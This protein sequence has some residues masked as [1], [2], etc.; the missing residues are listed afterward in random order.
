MSIQ[1]LTAPKICNLP[2]SVFVIRANGSIDARFFTT[3]SLAKCWATACL[4]LLE[5]D[6]FS[7]LNVHGSSVLLGKRKIQIL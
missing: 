1:A 5:R 6:Y 7:G 4:D 3:Y 2:F